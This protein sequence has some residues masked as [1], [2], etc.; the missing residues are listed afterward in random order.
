MPIT[1]IWRMGMTTWGGENKG[2]N[3]GER[4]TGRKNGKTGRKNGKTG[5][6]EGK[7]GENGKKWEKLEKKGWENRGEKTG[8]KKKSLREKKGRK[9]GEKR[10]TNEKKPNIPENSIMTSFIFVWTAMTW[11]DRRGMIRTTHI[12]RANHTAPASF[13]KNLSRFSSGTK[14]EIFGVFPEFFRYPPSYLRNSQ[15]IPEG[16]FTP[17]AP[18]AENLARPPT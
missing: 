2:K 4:E 11:P 14:K 9:R 5:G 16:F 12:P 13:C 7:Q 6:G 3:K 8:V 17:W 18:A 10:E 1:Q 15:K